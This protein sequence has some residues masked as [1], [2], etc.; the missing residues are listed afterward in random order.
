MLKQL[1]ECIETAD[2]YKRY[3]KVKQAVGLMIESKG[4]ECSIGDV[5]KIYTKGDG[6]KAIKAEVVGFKDQNILLMPYLEAANIA[7]GSIV[8]A[9]GESLR[10]K[11]GSGLIGQVV[12]AFGNPLDGSVLPKGLAQVSTD[13]APPNPMKR[14]PIREKMA[15][16]V[17]SID[18][19]LTVG[20]GQR[21]GIFAG[22][23]V[24]KSTLMGM[25][26]RET[27]ADLNVIALVGERGREVREFIEKDLGEEGLKRTI[28]VVA[29]S[30]QP[31]LM[32]LKAAYTATAIAEYFRD[33]GQNVMF[34]MD[35][36]TR[37]AMAQREI[38]LATGEPPTTKGYT[39]SVFAILPKLLERTG[40]TE[41]GSIT[42]FYT[43]LVDGDDMNEPIADTVRGILDGHIVLDRALAN[44]GQFPAVN[45]LKSIS[46]V[47][48]NIAEKDHIRAANRFREMLSTYQNSE[49]LINI[50]AYKKGSSREI[51]EAIQFHPK[52]ISF[53]KQEVD[54]AASL[55]ESI[56]LLK[57][58]TG[59]ED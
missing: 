17:R 37:V 54:E 13:Q 22:S 23:G 1:L 26:A 20:K 2:S 34:M 30:D 47:M 12:D 51:D 28:V 38:G 19:L 6:P 4:P 42:A 35:S 53:L 27:A 52:L 14:P 8:E 21:V 33:K 18:S 3:G 46:R 49:D 50:G 56:S 40:T 15:V 58:L 48:S 41:S 25:I 9:T 16:G 24:G 43:V 57:S 32:R 29:T 10:V 59:R 36:V 7:P 45:I 11:V 5:C 31:A 55:E 44:K 39:P